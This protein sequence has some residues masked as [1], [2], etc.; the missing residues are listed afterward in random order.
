MGAMRINLFGIGFLLILALGNPLE[1]LKL[2]GRTPSVNNAVFLL[3]QEVI[4]SQTISVRKQRKETT[5]S[6]FLTFSTGQS[7]VFSN[8]AMVGSGGS[9]MYY[10]IYNDG[11]NRNILKDLSTQPDSSEVLT[12][13]FAIN[14]NTSQEVSFV[15]ILDRDQ[16]PLA[17]NYLDEVTIG[18]YG[19]TP[20]N[21]ETLNPI[22]TAVMSISAV[23][24]PVMEM[25]LVPEGT[26]FDAGRSEL[27]L[28]FGTLFNGQT[29]NADLLVR[30]NSNYSVLLRSNNSGRMPIRDTAD[31]SVVPYSL[32]VNGSLLD[33][34]SGT[35]QTAIPTGTPST[36]NGTRY[37][38][39]VVIGDF[40]MASEGTYSDV[41][42]ITL[43]AQ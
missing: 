12:G 22:E 37:K 17:G 5:T 28:D 11:T 42:T 3:D 36:E 20:E 9:L 25:S 13:T 32:S 29:R 1:A 23:M 18:L 43:V 34:G 31:T 15:V 27:T 26:S 38:L 10:G 4:I 30:S 33:L 40:G 8:R 39:S 2:Q 7:G 41:L 24:D 21:P 35:D 19:G 6:F 16:F 14:D